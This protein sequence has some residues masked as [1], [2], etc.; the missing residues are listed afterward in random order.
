MEC[1]LSIWVRS[2]RGA[3]WAACLDDERGAVYAGA[4]CATVLAGRSGHA[5]PA[6]A[7]ERRSPSA[8]C[9]VRHADYDAVR[10]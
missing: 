4:A 3:G 7:A 5:V 8:A 9:R 6:A 10:L 1:S 2:V